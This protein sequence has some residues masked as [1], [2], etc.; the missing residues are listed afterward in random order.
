MP[1]REDAWRLLC[2]WTQSEALRRH[3]LGVETV[4]RALARRAGEDEELW[5]LTGLLHDFDYERYPQA[6]DHPTKGSEVLRGE[7]YP[8]VM[9]QAILGHADYTG[10]ARVT[11]LAKALFASDELTGFLFACA[12]VQPDRRVA[13][14]KPE[15]AKKKLKDKSFARGVNRDDIRKGAE[16][17][18]V[19]LLEHIIFVRDALAESADRFGL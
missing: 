9:I 15:S 19:D 11:P 18:G 1:N 3:A 16:E 12:Y 2:E 14:V 13:S 10:V 7:G 6:P 8:E 5:G 17:M 4:M